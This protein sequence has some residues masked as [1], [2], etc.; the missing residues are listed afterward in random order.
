MKVQG[1][2]L[3]SMLIA[4]GCSRG[5][6]LSTPEAD[7][8]YDGLARQEKSTLQNLWIKTDIDLARYTGYQLDVDLEFR[9]PRGDDENTRTRE[10]TLAE[11]DRQSLTEVVENTFRK[12][13][14]KSL[15]F[16]ES[17]VPGPDVARFHIR[18]IDIVA[19]MPKNPDEGPGANI[20]EASTAA[21]F[22]SS[23]GEASLVGE[24]FDSTTGEIIAR[25]VERR[26]AQQAVG[27][28]QSSRASGW[29]EIM[30]GLERWGRI[31]REDMDTIH[32]L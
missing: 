27:G 22:V 20:D 1:F 21:L 30:P 2:L 8:T 11:A 5:I 6:T 16:K 15:Y 29:R 13:L 31:V 4:T 12:E 17:P 3:A 9:V 23:V 24:V 32:D 18:L 14:L 19:L 26:A 7:I 10:F 25:F 28:V